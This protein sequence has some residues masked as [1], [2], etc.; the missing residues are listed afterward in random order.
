MTH[1]RMLAVCMSGQPRIF[2]EYA[3]EYRNTLAAVSASLSTS[4]FLSIHKD[5]EIDGRLQQQVE[6]LKPARHE[7]WTARAPCSPPSNCIQLGNASVGMRGMRCSFYWQ[8]TSVKRAYNLMLGFEQQHGTREASVTGHG[9]HR[10]RFAYVLRLR[11]DTLCPIAQLQRLFSDT[12]LFGSAVDPFTDEIFRGMTRNGHGPDVTST[13]FSDMAWLSTRIV[14]ESVMT[15]I[16]EF[17]G[18]CGALLD[19][20][21]LQSRCPEPISFMYYECILLARMLAKHPNVRL[22]PMLPDRWVCLKLCG[23]GICVDRDPERASISSSMPDHGTP[24]SS[25]TNR[26]TRTIRL[27]SSTL[28]NIVVR[29]RD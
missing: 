25:G 27:P 10:V 20:S 2:Q 12:A 6:L 18:G 29:A 22:L 28:S 11:T 9:S 3:R 5:G 26:T 17:D 15:V 19:P 16:D 7:Y 14:A 21:V 1:A 23:E 4:L 24:S 8:F 13:R